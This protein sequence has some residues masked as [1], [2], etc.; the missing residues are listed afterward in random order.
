MRF[1]G[2][3]TNLYGAQEHPYT[4]Q[5]D[6]IVLGMLFCGSGSTWIALGWLHEELDAEDPSR[7]PTAPI[8]PLYLRLATPSG[9]TFKERP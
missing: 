9:R 5:K 6:K 4:K 7:F 1:Q 2:I 3:E 8:K